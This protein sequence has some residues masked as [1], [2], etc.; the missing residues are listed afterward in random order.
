MPSIQVY[1]L[2]RPR[3]LL[4]GIE[5]H[6]S[7]KKMEA[8]LYYLLTEGQA[9]RSCVIGLLWDDAD[10]PQAYQNLRHA[11]YALRRELG[12]SFLDASS[13]SRLQ[14]NPQLTISCDLWDFLQKQDLDAYQGSFLQDFSVRRAKPFDEWRERWQVR[15]REIYLKLLGMQAREAARLGDSAQA[16]RLCQRYLQEDPTDEGITVLL[17]R[18][19]QQQHQ[20]VKATVLYQELMRRLEDELGITPLK[21]TTA[22]YYEILNRWNASATGSP[23]QTCEVPVGKKRPRQRLSEALSY[24]CSGQARAG[25]LLFQGE[26]GVGKSFLLEYARRLAQEQGLWSAMA[27]CYP[28]EQDTPFQPWYSLLMQASAVSGCSLAQLCPSLV[29][30]SDPGHPTPPALLPVVQEEILMALSRTAQKR[31]L[32]LIFEDIHW[33]DS[34]SLSILHQALRRLRNERIL[35]LCSSSNLLPQR[36]QTFLYEGKQDGLLESL[37]IRS[38]SLEETREFL[39]LS[40]VP[41]CSRALAEQVYTHTSGN[42]LKL[43]QL[44]PT[45]TEGEP[46]I[47]LGKKLDQLLKLRLKNLLPES[48]QV[49]NLISV[50][51]QGAPFSILVSITGRSKRELLC[52]CDDLERRL[53]IRDKQAGEDVILWAMP[54]VQVLLQSKLSR[55]SQRLLHLRVADCLEESSILPE[56]ERLEQCIYHFEQGN[57]AE[58]ALQCRLL[59]LERLLSA[60]PSLGENRLEA[61]FHELDERLSPPHQPDVP[62]A[63]KE[64]WLLQ[65]GRYL[66][67]HGRS[68]EGLAVLQDLSRSSSSPELCR[69]AREAAHLSP[70]SAACGLYPLDHEP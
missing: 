48:R 38:F 25:A 52:I 11:L 13:K 21:E 45:L 33:M 67:G 20:F 7:Y 39:S 15:L 30:S 56:E 5:L 46:D 65:K 10:N 1:L 49:L 18:L 28:S 68:Q 29:R 41:H 8:L 35:I 3:V 66:M 44:L 16:V 59:L 36:M 51:P 31:P 47:P 23:A 2:Q 50:F 26:A 64:L 37:T 6:F 17:M 62:G 24:L 43:R 40:G 54:Q 53:L 27:S 12:C 69:R 63:L 58:K 4:D 32:L 34:S 70:G 57:E 19:Y 61:L 60:S 14:L 22:V 9:E 55:L 42:A